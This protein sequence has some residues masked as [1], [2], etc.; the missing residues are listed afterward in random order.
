MFFFVPAT[1]WTPPVRLEVVLNG[2][3]EQNRFPYCYSEESRPSLAAA[4]GHVS[5]AR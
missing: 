3:K 4:K 1:L 2:I 5:L